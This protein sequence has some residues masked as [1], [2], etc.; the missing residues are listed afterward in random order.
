[1]Q[2][3]A[4][5]GAGVG[6]GF[7]GGVLG[8]GVEGGGVVVGGVLEAVGAGLAALPPQATRA[9]MR[10]RAVAQLRIWRVIQGPTK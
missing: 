4:V 10:T 1:M 7:D 2:L 9:V 8:G 6:V 3:G 5:D